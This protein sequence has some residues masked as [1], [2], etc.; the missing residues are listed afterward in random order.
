MRKITIAALALSFSGSMAFAQNASNEATAT[1]V[2]AGPEDA[3]TEYVAPRSGQTE[4]PIWSENFSAGIPSTWVNAGKDGFGNNLP[5]ALWVYRGPG[6]TPSNAVGSTGAYAGPNN[7]GNQGAPMVSPTAANGFVIFDSDFLDN[8]GTRG[9]FGNGIAPAPH[10]GTLTTPTINLT[11]NPNVELKLNSY[12]RYF[13]GRALVALS[14]NGGLTWPDTLAAHP[15]LAV[16]AATATNAVVSWNVSSIIGGQANVKLRFIFDGTYDDPGASG[17]GMGYYFWMIDDIEINALVKHE[18]RFTDWNGAPAQDIIYGP[19]PSSATSLGSS[20]MGIMAKNSGSD[21]T[22]DITFD[23]NAYNFGYGALTNVKLKVEIYDIANTLLTSYTSTTGVNLSSGDTADYND[24]NTYG[25][26]WNANAVGTYRIVYKAI[27]D[28]ATAISDTFNVFVTDSLMSLDNNVFT[29]SLGTDNLGDDGSAVASRID[30][31]QP[32]VM[33]GVW[34][35]LST[36]TVPGGTLEIVIADSAGFDFATAGFPATSLRGQSDPNNP[37]TITAADIAAGFVQIPVN[38]GTNNYVA[39]SSGAYYVAVYMY[40]NNGSSTI[41][42]RND[43]TFGAPTRS[44]AMFNSDDNRWYSGYSGGRQF[45]H[46]WIRAKFWSAIGLEENILNSNVNVGPNP[47]NDVLNV[48]FTNI[49]GDFTLTMTDVTGR[50]IRTESISVFGA[51]NHTMNVNGLAK[52][53]Y[54]LNINNGKASVTH[55]ISVQ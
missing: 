46:M 16:N 34:V 21:Q 11:G 38:D 9:N 51:A 53:V 55:K 22:R 20:K 17:S 18:L 24:M 14:T 31:V 23:G 30:L 10:V 12:H 4:T 43:Q 50:V 40:S 52:G 37:Y 25:N 8:A 28:S 19:Q 45:N 2:A 6:T 44:I 7:S 27:S 42:I 1:R 35:G 47:V 33:K 29:N 32:A 49:D 26:P 54:M 48:N 5:N 3:R 41:R 36:V 15:S 13:E 39:L